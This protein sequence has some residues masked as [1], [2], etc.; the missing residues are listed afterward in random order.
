MTATLL[1]N[2]TSSFSR[3]IVG[4]KDEVVTV[5]SQHDKVFIVKGK[6]TFSVKIEDLKIEV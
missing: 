3:Q 5:I 6:D 2:I 1:S 4:K